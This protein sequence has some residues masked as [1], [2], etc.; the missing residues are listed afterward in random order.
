M[1][2]PWSKPTFTARVHKG[3][4]GRWHFEVHSPAKLIQ[5]ISPPQGYLEERQAWDA[6]KRL[7]DSKVV[8]E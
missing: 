3:K 1:R 6:I 4:D 2:F 5:A 8:P 7:S